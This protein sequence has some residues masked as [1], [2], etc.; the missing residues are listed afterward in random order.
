M[1][2]TEK[3]Y[4]CVELSAADETAEELREQGLFFSTIAEAI[5]VDYDAIVEID[6]NIFYRTS[7]IRNEQSNLI[8]QTLVR[9]F[10]ASIRRRC[11][12]D[13]H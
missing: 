7:A 1:T 10:G 13:L 3:I 11:G 12:V 5:D 8:R 9:A 2:K 4:L 6:A